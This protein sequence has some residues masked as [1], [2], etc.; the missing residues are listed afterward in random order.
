MQKECNSELFCTCI[1]CKILVIWITE[2][3]ASIQG[4]G[5]VLWFEDVS[6]Y[7]LTAEE[8]FQIRGELSSNKRIEV[9][10]GGFKQLARLHLI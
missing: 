3:S 5:T 10:S 6:P 1:W 9:Q 2:P 7:R 4:N 8:A